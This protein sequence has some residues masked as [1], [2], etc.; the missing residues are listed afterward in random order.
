MKTVLLFMVT[1]LIF[2]NIYAEQVTIYQSG[3]STVVRYINSSGNYDY[4]YN[5][6]HSI[7]RHDGNNGI[8][9]G[10]Q[11]DIWRSEHSFYLGSIPSNATITQAQLQFFISGYQCSTCSL[12]VTKTTGQYSY[13]Q[14]WTNINNTN[15]IVASYV[16][17]A[18]TPVVST[19]LKD[20][21][22]ASL[23]TGTMY[24]GSLS[25]VEGSNNSYASLELRLIV[26]Y[27]VPPSI[28]NITAD[29]NFTASG[30]AN[31][32][33]MVIDGVNRT[34][35]LTP[36]GYTFQKTV[37][38]NLTLS[39]NSPQNDNQGHQRIWHTGLTFPSD[40]RRNG[41]FKSYNQTYSFPV[42]TDD[43]GKIYMANLRKNFKI[44][45]THKTEFDGNQTQQ[46]TA[47][48][49]ELNS[50]NISTQ[51][52]RL[53]NG[54]NYLFAGWED[55]LSLGTSRNI[56]PTDNKV[57]NVLY[58]HPHHSNTITAYQNPG[59]RRFIKTNSGHLHMVYESMGKIFYERSTNNGQTWEIMN[60]GKPIYSGIATHPSIDFYPGTNDII[61]VYN[62]DES[63][64]AA[65]Y[66]ENG[67]FKCE[68]IVADNSIWDQVTPD[69]K[70]VIA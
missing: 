14:L 23:T 6:L 4:T 35:P 16:Y 53:L 13:G 64:I 17:N 19:A 47:W 10:S 60:G 68:S 67:I 61:I 56:T 49:V 38:Q 5:T 27:T 63:V 34:I 43:D 1:I 8:N 20:A 41:E 26:D 24:L 30:G 48:I 70:P 28:V 54:K 66:Y 69:S 18:T 32:G 11:N 33:T 65:Q 37:G 40:W 42:A 3:I 39:A 31:R 2:G 44:D 57:Y 22:I 36:P 46:N 29:N 50:D 15:T 51:S 7:G 12:K 21:I 52:S 58:K 45:Q 55:N 25:L 59:Q 62:R 9:S